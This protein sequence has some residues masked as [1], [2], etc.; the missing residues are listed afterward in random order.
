MIENIV[1]VNDSNPIINESSAVENDRNMLL[2]SSNTEQACDTYTDLSILE[3]IAKKDK[4]SL[5]YTPKFYYYSFITLMIKNQ[6]H[7]VHCGIFIAAIIFMIPILLVFCNNS[8][9]KVWETIIRFKI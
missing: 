3:S 5:P 8:T 2:E 4:E 1:E 9:G 7:L 6:N